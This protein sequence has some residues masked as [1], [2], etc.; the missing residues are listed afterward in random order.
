[1]CVCKCAFVCVCV[2]ASLIPS[3]SERRSLIQKVFICPLPLI[4][5]EPRGTIPKL[6][7]NTMCGPS[8]TLD[9]RGCMLCIERFVHAPAVCA[10]RTDASS[11]RPYHT[12]TLRHTK[13]FRSSGVTQQCCA[14]KLLAATSEQCTI[15]GSELDSIRLEVLTVSPKRQ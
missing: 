2:C 15:P 14:I 10:C 9:G 12:E 11:T 1:M 13:T 5:M 6:C 3:G 7:S 4:G 8:R